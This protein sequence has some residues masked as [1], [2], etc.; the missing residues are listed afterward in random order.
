ME[1]RCP[2]CDSF[3]KL[4]PLFNEKK[5]AY[6]YV[7]YPCKQTINDVSDEWFWHDDQYVERSTVL[8]DEPLGEHPSD[9]FCPQ[10]PSDTSYEDDV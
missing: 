8:E 9:S 2:I 6:D 5:Q 7:C 4:S 1:S 10:G 3:T